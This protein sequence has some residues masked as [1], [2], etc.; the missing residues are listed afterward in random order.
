MNEYDFLKKVLNKG[1]LIKLF[2][3][4]D[5]DVKKFCFLYKGEWLNLLNI[6]ELVNDEDIINISIN[7]PFDFEKIRLEMVEYVAFPKGL[8]LEDIID[9]SPTFKKLGDDFLKKNQDY[10]KDIKKEIVQYKLH[11]KENL[12]KFLKNIE[13]TQDKKFEDVLILR[14]YPKKNFE[15]IKSVDDIK[16]DI[17]NKYFIVGEQLD[18]IPNN[19]VVIIPA[20]TKLGTSSSNFDV[21]DEVY[22]NALKRQWFRLITDEKEKLYNKLENIKDFSLSEEELEEYKEELEI[23]K[24]E[25]DSISLSNFDN[26]KT[27][28]E[29]I[30]YWPELL[31]PKP[32]FVYED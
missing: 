7:E 25:I 32:E 14:F 26:F 29:I 18:L 4:D 11:Y 5:S 16:E 24:N 27:V 8:L 30:S 10:L 1:I 22:L 17:K 3:Y 6:Q 9:P 20:L 13:D 23:F 28:K 15:N 12:E 2:Y 19:D 31:Q 21:T